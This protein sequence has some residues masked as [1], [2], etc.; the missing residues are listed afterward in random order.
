MV[1]RR[2]QD[3]GYADIEYRAANQADVVA[4]AR[5]RSG[6]WGGERYW[7]ARI[8]GYLNGEIN[9]QHAL[10]PRTVVVASSDDVV[11]G[12][13]AGHLT[14]RHDCDGELQWL[15]VVAERR[16]SGIASDL[17]RHLATWFA[18]HR[19]RRVCVD[20]DPGN[21]PARAFY[22]QYGAVDL[23]PHW[24]VWSDLPASIFDPRLPRRGAD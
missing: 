17:L 2:P 12:F 1:S 22:R 6:T 18:D 3:S 13:I 23:S 9:P 21:E 19:V 16:R 14:R 15:H 20:V 11:V 8:A 7:Q 10:A 4:L 24:L 5:I